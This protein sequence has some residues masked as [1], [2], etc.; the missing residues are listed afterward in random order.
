[1]KKFWYVYDQLEKT[2]LHPM[3]NLLESAQVLCARLNR[4]HPGR[5]QC[6]DWVSE[7]EWRQRNDTK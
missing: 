6:V 5:Y 2:R 1:M 3:F 7:R 4:Q